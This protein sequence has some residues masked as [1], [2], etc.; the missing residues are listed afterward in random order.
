MTNHTPKSGAQLLDRA[1]LLLDLVA[2]GSR[3][4]MTLKALCEQ[5]ELNK[6]TC[7]RI[8]NS[9]AEHGMLDKDP[10]GRRYRLGTKLLVL[11]AKAANG[12]GLRSLCQPAL[13]RL[14]QES[15]ETTMLMARD[16]DDSVCIDRHDGS[17]LLQTLT[18][19]IGGYVPLGVGPGSLSMLAFMA[20]DEREEVLERNWPRIAAYPALTR[21]K[22]R[23][24]ID[25]TISQGYALDRG[26]LVPGVAGIA[27]PI[28]VAETGPVASL[29]FTILS[30]RL[31]SEMIERY[32]QAL[33]DEV[34]SIEPH[35]NPLDR[36]LTSPER[37][38]GQS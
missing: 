8:L 5:A 28:R 1:V 36:R 17:F 24:L 33:R 19:S 3:E 31:S 16:R 32:V 22:L 37:I 10:D 15:G 35:L 4:G 26:E 23:R 13:T 27:V 38:L 34:A 14:C 7:H 21:D 9:L 20:A 29:G 2:G 11:G 6:A 30:A 25:E 12:P 18:G